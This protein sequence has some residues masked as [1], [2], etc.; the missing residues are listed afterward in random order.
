MYICSCRLFARSCASS[1]LLVA[2]ATVAVLN[3]EARGWAMAQDSRQVI[4]LDGVWEIAEG[5]MAVVPA[6]LRAQDRRAGAH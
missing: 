6:S 2:A 5:S 3:P 4:S 1:L